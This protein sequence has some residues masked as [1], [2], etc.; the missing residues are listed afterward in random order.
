MPNEPP[1]PERPATGP[2][3]PGTG[4]PNAPPPSSFLSSNPAPPSRPRRR[5]WSRLILPLVAIL[6]VLAA[7]YYWF[8]MR[9]YESTDDAFIE[10]DVI[11]IAPQVPGRVATL[12]VRD[13]ELVRHGQLLVEIDPR[14]YQAK[15]AQAEADLAAA[16]TRLDQ[17]KAQVT[18]DE[19]KV[20]EEQA[21]LVSNQ[22]QAERANSDLRRYQ[23]LQTPAV[24]RTQL[25]LAATQATSSNAG[26]E[27]AQS[28]T[29]A[30]QA[31]VNLSKAAVETA[32]AQVQSYEAAVRQAQLNLS[33]TKITTPVDGFIT[34]RSVQVGSY[35]QIGQSL[36][37]LVPTNLYAV[38]NFK[39]TQLTKMRPGQPVKISVDAYPHHAFH[40]HVDSIQRGSGARF[41]LL[42]P[43]NATGNYV[44]VVQRIPVKIYFDDPP[45][46]DFPL[47]PG[48][49]VVPSVSIL[50]KGN[51][52]QPTVA[53][54]TR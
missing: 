5:G 44:K 31:Q 41:S 34:A 22:S 8:F 32:A 12:A 25:D 23:S 42:P 14:D 35:I 7:L 13:N 30:A 52:G 36:L 21:N 3:S 10:A 24:A 37:A 40:G 15:L 17:A 19:A 1:N 53:Q 33:Y 26:V 43:E 2:G 48:M 39:E 27:V 29:K 47:G 51:H 38:A 54:E 4:P 9:P 20:Q 50:A 49:S 6:L 45:D 16:K 28:R 11:P 46:P 18:A